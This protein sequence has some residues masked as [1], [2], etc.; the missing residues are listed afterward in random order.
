MGQRGPTGKPTKKKILQGT[1][2]KDRAPNNEAQPD[3]VKPEKPTWMKMYKYRVDEN[4]DRDILKFANDYWDENA[5]SMARNGL[6]TEIDIQSFSML[7]V[8]FGE[9]INALLKQ[10][11]Q[12]SIIKFKSGHVDQHPYSI[13]ADKAYNKYRQMAKQFGVTPASRSGIEAEIAQADKKTE[14]NKL[15][16]Q[17]VN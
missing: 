1:F 16:N 3:I 11:K 2:R 13:R 6:L 5:D 4:A 9:W 10:V 8:A 17:E 14:I 15:L 12:G 7:C